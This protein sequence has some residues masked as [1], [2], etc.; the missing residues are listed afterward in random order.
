V[1]GAAVP[2]APENLQ[3]SLEIIQY[4]NYLTG[5]YSAT[6]AGY[7]GAFGFLTPDNTN[8]VY[9]APNVSFDFSLIGF[10]NL[11]PEQ[12]EAV[13][14]QE[15]KAIVGKG[16]TPIIHW[17]WHDYGPTQWNV[18][19]GPPKY[20]LAM[21]TNFIQRAYADG[22]E[23]VTGADLAQRI[24]SFVASDITI[25]Q[26]NGKLVATV[27]ES[28]VGKFALNVET[29]QVIASVDNWY[30]FDGAKVF[31]PKDGG[32][33]AI[34]LGSQAADVTRI[35]ELPMRA[36]LLSA[37][38]N[39]TDLDF[40][41]NG[42]GDVKVDLK[43]WGT[44]SVIA[45]G[46]DSGKLSGEVLTLSFGNLG[47]HSMTID[48]LASDLVIGT[49]GND[50]IIGSDQGRTI[51]GGLGNDYLFGGGGEDVFVYRVGGGIDTVLDFTPN[52]DKIQLIGSGFATAQEAL[53]QFFQDAGGLT[54]SFSDND[55][56]VLA[57]TT[58]IGEEHIFLA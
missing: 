25:S 1:I 41:L 24:Q 50:F 49:A 29:N 39:G 48:Y 21:F 40:A 53:A 4:F 38:G 30:A 55:R 18:G 34:T 13:W 31:L 46:A 51:D 11:T 2:G 7:T 42:R 10:R 28:D 9:F 45:T 22:A 35:A 17:P 47:S 43:A 8:K 12:A 3:T 5:G 6:G 32:T 54:L 33:F 19:D 56:L 27:T 23:F 36:E 15:Y 20:T 37:N 58:Q 16:T 14:T 26:E 52:L 44:D 57:N